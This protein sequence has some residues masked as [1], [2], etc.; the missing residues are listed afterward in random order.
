[1]VGYCA[2]WSL[3]EVYELG[4]LP[5]PIKIPPPQ[6]LEQA[7][8]VSSNFLGA[9]QSEWAGAQAFNSFD[10]FTAKFA[11]GERYEKIKEGV[12][13]FIQNLNLT[14]RWGGQSPFTNLTF[15]LRAPEDL[16]FF[17]EFHEE[18]D[19]INKAFLEVMLEGDG[20]HRPYTFPIPT[21]NITKDF[22]WDSEVSD[23][24]FELAAKYGSPYFAN[25][26]NSDLKPSDVRSMCC[27]LRLDLRELRRNITSGLFGSGDK[28]GSIGVVTINMPRIGYLS[29]DD[30]EFFERVANL[31]EIA[32]E[33][34]ILKRKL[35]QKLM[36]IGMLP[37]TKKYLG[38]LDFHFNTIGLIGM[39]EACLNFLGEGIWE[40]EAK[41]FAERVLDFMLEKL[42][43][44]QM[45]TKLLWNLEATPAEGASFRLAKLDKKYFRDII[46]SGQRTP[47]YTNSTWLPVDYTD[48]IFEVLEHQESL[49]TR[50][51][52]GTVVHIWLGERISGE[53]AKELVKKIF[54]KYRIPYITI[55]PTYSVCKNHGIF[56][57]EHKRC[58]ICGAETEVFSRV[59]GYL[60]P[61]KQWNEGK[62]EEFRERKHFKID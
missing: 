51:T 48:D 12:K 3:K 1:M 22:P 40:K 10:T 37:Y 47:Y 13:L 18:M 36:D 20:E 31:M 16:K 57:G 30:D 49:Q 60:R 28:T 11:R 34:L 6:N 43:E 7:F 14:S 59:V 39:H 29:K 19:L 41:R 54:K 27:R 15:D 2:G 38:T 33:S 44:F 52:G 50:Y 61:V 23:L 56:Y 45:E 53:D 17:E 46:T 62:Q 24:I 8:F 35:V 4:I 42:K 55:T 26:I 5:P 25:F 58:P 21:Y 9:I 32:K